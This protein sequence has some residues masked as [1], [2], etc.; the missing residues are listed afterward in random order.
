M[1]ISESRKEASLSRLE[2]M[3]LDAG[4]RA[5]PSNYLVIRHDL[6]LQSLQ[7]TLL[8]ALQRMSLRTYALGHE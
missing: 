8:V 4:R 6:N 2:T 1:K 7:A 3:I 5:I